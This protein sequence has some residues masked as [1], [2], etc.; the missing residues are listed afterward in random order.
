MEDL[1]LNWDDIFNTTTEKKTI[2]GT[3]FA[4]NGKIIALSEMPDH[5][6]S[7]L[8]R[9]TYND[10][11]DSVFCLPC[12]EWRDIPCADPS[13]EYCAERPKKPSDCQEL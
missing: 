11:F 7:C 1:G 4:N 2:E 5:C 12:D 3:F 10:E 9:L 8:E 13:C 6:P